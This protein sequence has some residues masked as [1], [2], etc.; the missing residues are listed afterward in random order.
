[1]TPQEEHRAK[2][3]KGFVNLTLKRLPNKKEVGCFEE[4]AHYV[5]KAALF[6]EVSENV[7]KHCVS[8][9]R[10]WYNYSDELV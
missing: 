10:E 3:I 6:R 7:I 2:Q 9:F 1:M 8:K 5:I 4:E